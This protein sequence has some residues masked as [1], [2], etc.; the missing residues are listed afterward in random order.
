MK[1]IGTRAAFILMLLPIVVYLGGYLVLRPQQYRDELGRFEGVI[2]RSPRWAIRMVEI[3]I[4]VAGL[5]FSYL[6]LAAA[7]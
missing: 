4:I 2:S 7:K 5:A 6:F 3:F 1:D